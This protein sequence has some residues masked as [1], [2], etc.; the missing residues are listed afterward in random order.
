MKTQIIITILVLILVGLISATTIYAGDT[1]I[2]PL[3]FEIVNC[4]ISGNTYNLDGLNLS[5][6]NDKII[7][8]THLLYQPDTF[9]VNCFVIIGGK[10]IE[11][12][13]SGGGG[14]YHKKDKILNLTDNIID[15][16]KEL[17]L[18]QLLEDQNKTNQTEIIEPIDIIDAPEKPKWYIKFWSWI[19]R[20]F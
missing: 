12:P 2:I 14:S 19:K 11:H 4:S 8:S 1:T 15:L 16:R 3:D 20:I 7:V 17:L 6:E 18:K 5:W 10:I 13:Y 9:L